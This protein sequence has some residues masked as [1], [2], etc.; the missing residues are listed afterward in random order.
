MSTK[1]HKFRRHFGRPE[2]H[3]ENNRA[4]AE[5]ILAKAQP[6]DDGL[7]IHWARA[8][9]ADGQRPQPCEDDAHGRVIGRAKKSL[10]L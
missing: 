9:L 8:V 6:G 3:A 10:Y 7:A 4:A 1:A 2:V 5:L